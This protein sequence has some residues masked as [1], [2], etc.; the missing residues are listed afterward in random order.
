MSKEHSSVLMQGA[1]G[2]ILAGV[3]GIQGGFLL[4]PFALACL[5]S[6]SRNIAAS[7]LWGSIALLISHRWLLSLHPLD[8]I[9]VPAPL[10]LPIAILIWLF[11]GAL[12]GGLVGFWSWVG[13]WPQFLG[14]REGGFRQQIF[15]ALTMAD[16]GGLAEVFL[17][18][19]SLVWIGM[20]N[21]LWP[22][23]IRLAGWARWI[24]AGGLATLQLL[25]GWWL[26][27]TTTFF[28][29]GGK[30]RI[31]LFIGILFVVLTHGIGWTLLHSELVAETKKVA[32]WQTAIPIRKKFS[33]GQKLRMPSA[34]QNSLDRAN[35]LGADWLVAPEGTLIPNQKLLSNPP[36]PFLSGGFRWINGQQRS[37]LMV[38]DEGGESSS[39]VIDKYRLVPLGEW[40]P[41]FSGMGFRGLSAVGGLQP[42]E[43]SRLMSWSGPPVA[44]AICYEL[45]NGNALAHAVGGGAEWILTIANLDPYPISL[46]RQFLSLAQLRSIETSRDL[47][48]VANTGPSAVIKSSG[49]IQEVIPPFIEDVGLADLHLNKAITGYVRWRETPLIVLFFISICGLLFSNKSTKK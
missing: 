11:C 10:S 46:Q 6:V 25:I 44:V 49:E 34:I 2:G 14:L 38:F 7:A 47:I 39:A 1:I 33:S 29:R 32:L 37:S 19:T 4:M 31:F 24:G 20:G 27:I 15:L 36:I 35:K 9:G 22:G 30:W 12:A 43:S 48:S 42:G 28:R 23:D 8:W 13:R 18:N 3:S 5:W 41:R 26:W 17:A 40:T 45:S 16:V 21:S